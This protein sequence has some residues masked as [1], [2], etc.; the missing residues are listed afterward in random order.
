MDMQIRWN[1]WPIRKSLPNCQIKVSDCYGNLFLLQLVRQ[2]DSVCL[3]FPPHRIF[4]SLIA[5]NFHTLRNV[6]WLYPSTCLYVHHLISLLTLCPP[7]FKKKN[8]KPLSSIS[9]THMDMGKGST[10]KHEG[11]TRGHATK[12]EWL[13]FLQK[14]SRASISLSKDGAS[15][16]L[17]PSM[18]WNFDWFDLVPVLCKSSRP[19]WTDK[20]NYLKYNLTAHPFNIAAVGSP[21]RSMISQVWNPWC[22]VGLI[23]NQNMLG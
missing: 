1:L 9:A 4:C 3:P 22:R 19:L 16:A 17:P 7:F 6:F 20:H 15:V 23:S 2:G 14:S 12:G 18:C 5:W 8:Y 21:L 11:L 13:S 10:L